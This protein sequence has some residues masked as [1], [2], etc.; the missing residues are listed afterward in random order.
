MN[1]AFETDTLNILEPDTLK[2]TRDDSGFLNLEYQNETSYHGR[3]FIKHLF[4]IWRIGCHHHDVKNG[5]Y[6]T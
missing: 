3:C 6:R 1:N 2:F 5:G 4:V